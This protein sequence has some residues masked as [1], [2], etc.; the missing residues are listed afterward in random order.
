MT[1]RQQ[2]T[3][4]LAVAIAL[5]LS[6]QTED[7]R[8]EDI[9]ALPKISDGYTTFN[10]EIV[11]TNN[12]QGGNLL[13]SYIEGFGL[14][15]GHAFLYSYGLGLG[16]GGAK[17]DGSITPTFNGELM[18]YVSLAPPVHGCHTSTVFWSFGFKSIVIP[19]G[20]G[21]TWPFYVGP[22]FGPAIVTEIDHNRCYSFHNWSSGLDVEV[23][24]LSYVVF[25]DLSRSNLKRTPA[26]GAVLKLLI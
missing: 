21:K 22:S 10:G 3:M 20:D 8:A 14:G 17:W 19:K 23:V 5:L 9:R 6:T 15:R 18:T 12:V 16:I 25:T 11:V 4:P 1:K 24:S 2:R 13:L 26:Y 7:A